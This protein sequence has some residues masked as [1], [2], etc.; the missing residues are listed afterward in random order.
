MDGELLL[1]F[2]QKQRRYGGLLRDYAGVPGKTVNESCL[3]GLLKYNHDILCHPGLQTVSTI[4][5][6]GALGPQIEELRVM[7]SF[8][9]NSIPRYGVLSEGLHN[10]Q[11]VEV[12]SGLL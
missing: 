2:K 10:T 3:S 12:L 4:A 6:K 5:I 9:E 11:D 8:T 1:R 7:E